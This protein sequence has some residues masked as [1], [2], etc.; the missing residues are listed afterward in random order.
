MPYSKVRQVSCYRLEL[1]VQSATQKHEMRHSARMNSLLAA[2]TSDIAFILF[3]T[4][5]QTALLVSLVSHKIIF[6]CVNCKIWP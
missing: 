4:R 3:H 1:G 6:L 5:S 2:I